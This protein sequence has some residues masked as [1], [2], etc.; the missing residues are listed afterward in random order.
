MRNLRSLTFTLLSILLVSGISYSA[1][2]EEPTHI[3]SV[4]IRIAQIPAKVAQHPYADAYIISRIQPGAPFTQRL[5]VFNTSSQEIKVEVYPGLATFINGDFLVGNGR[6]GNTLS[7]WTT[8]LPRYINLR[9]NEAKNFKV[10]ISPPGDASSIQQFGVIWAEVHGVEND[11][12]ITSISRVGIRMYLPVGNAPEIT[13]TE[14]SSRASTNEIIVTKSTLSIYL[15]EVLAALL[16][17]VIIFFGL[18]LLFFRRGKTDRKYRKENEKRLEAQW[19]RERD[20]RRKIWDKRKNA[21][22]S[23]RHDNN[24]E[25]YEEEDPHHY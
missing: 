10:T 11:S 7:S 17:S 23:R 16:L 8:T 5:E 4:G 2:A 20:R 21:Q 14:P 18:F 22:N 6:E 15:L 1:Q 19:K 9:P 3:G 12:G 24:H 25:N 13:I